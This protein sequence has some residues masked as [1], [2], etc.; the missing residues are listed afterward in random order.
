MDYNVTLTKY[1]NEHHHRGVFDMWT[2]WAQGPAGLP[3][4]LAGQPGFESA[5]P[6]I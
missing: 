5:Q 2:K 4:S 1:Q 6:E 3:N